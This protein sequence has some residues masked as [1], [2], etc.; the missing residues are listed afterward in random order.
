[1]KKKQ[2]RCGRISVIIL[3]SL[4]SGCW[5]NTHN[6]LCNALSLVEPIR[7][8]THGPASQKSATATWISDAEALQH[9]FTAINRYQ[10]GNDDNVAP[11]INWRRYGVLFIE[12]G[13][14]PTG[15]YSIGFTPSLSRVVDKQAFIR[16]SWNTPEEGVLLTQAVTSPFMLL[17]ICHTDI[18]SIVVLNQNELPLFEIP[19]K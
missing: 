16:I 5:F 11:D 1:M 9:V 19:I 12:M 14:K 2:S 17:K 15:G 6:Q 4:I 8:G 7:S 18:T 13:Q 10:L 3:F